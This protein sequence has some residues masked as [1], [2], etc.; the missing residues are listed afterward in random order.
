MGFPE[1]DMTLKRLKNSNT[2]NIL[3][4]LNQVP[5]KADGLYNKVSIKNNL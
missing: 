1:L 3:R 2:E 5:N 4:D